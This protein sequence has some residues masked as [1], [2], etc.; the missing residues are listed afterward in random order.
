MH[1]DRRWLSWHTVRAVCYTL[2]WLLLLELIKQRLP[3]PTLLKIFDAPPR[4]KQR[5]EEIAHFVR[6][7][8]VLLGWLYHR[9]FCFQ[10]SLLLFRYLRSCGYPVRIHYGVALHHEELRGHAWLTIGGRPFLERADPRAI[11]TV[12][13]TYPLHAPKHTEVQDEH[14]FQTYYQAKQASA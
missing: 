11:Y 6:A 9:D 4:K 12:V 3:L 7:V 2:R 14:L 1:I 5:E 10:R 8:E 13:Y